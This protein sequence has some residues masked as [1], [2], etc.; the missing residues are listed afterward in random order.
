L[1]VSHTGERQALKR[2][3]GPA[4]GG[5]PLGLRQ[6][7]RIVKCGDSSGNRPAETFFVMRAEIETI[8]EEIKQS[9][10]LLRRHL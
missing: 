1:P 3:T 2:S 9:A 7:A 6:G 10:S 5:R 4:D 8:V